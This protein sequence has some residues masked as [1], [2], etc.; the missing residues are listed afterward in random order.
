MLVLEDHPDITR[1]PETSDPPPP[2]DFDDG[3]DDGDDDAGEPVRWETVATYWKSTEA[4]I[5]RIKLESEDIDCLII[6]ENLVA[7]DWLWANA[8]GG[9]KLQVPQPDARRARELLAIPARAA[10]AA[11]D[12]PVADGQECC[13]RCGSDRIESSRFSRRF[14]FISI[15][16]LGLPL[17]MLRRG[18]RCTD[19]GFEFKQP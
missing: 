16:L 4:H 2:D 13:P 11:C 8:V 18:V 15:L 17:P 5:A 3:N 1:A 6:D 19:C 7:A 10:R 12:E 14:A 9:I